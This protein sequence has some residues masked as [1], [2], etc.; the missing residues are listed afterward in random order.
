MNT[1]DELEFEGITN[2]EFKTLMRELVN[3][4]LTKILSSEQF[5]HLKKQE[6][7]KITEQQRRDVKVIQDYWNEVASKPC[8]KLFH[9]SKLNIAQALSDR[10]KKELFRAIDIIWASPLMKGN[11]VYKKHLQSLDWCSKP[12]S[13]E[14]IFRGVY[15]LD[16]GGFQNETF[17]EE[18]E[19]YD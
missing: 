6:R 17:N 3:E 16:K 1:I 10:G 8:T 5:S 7:G 18:D 12:E 15:S 4:E 9:N 11:N 13:L 14:K 2:E 19:G